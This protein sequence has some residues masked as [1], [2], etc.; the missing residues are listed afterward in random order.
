MQPDRTGL[1]APAMILLA[2]VLS[3]TVDAATFTVTSTGDSGAGSLRQALASANG[4]AGTDTIEFADGVVGTITL[5]TALPQIVE[6]VTIDGPGADVL[7]VNGEDGVQGVSGDD[8]VRPFSIATGVQV[9]ISGLTIA[10]GLALDEGSPGSGGGISNRGDLTLRDCTL[11]GNSAPDNLGGAV[12][13]A[14]GATLLVER[15]TISGNLADIGGGISNDGTLTV[16]DSRIE[17]NTAVSQGGGIDNA[18]QATISRSLVVGNDSLFGGGIGTGIPQGQSAGGDLF[19]VNSTMSGNSVSGEFAIGGGIDN[20][21]GS[22]E[23]LHATIARNQAPQGAGV[24]SDGD[25]AAKNSLVVENDGG[26]CEFIQ[27]SFAVSGANLATD[28]SCPNFT[29]VS[30][31][32]LALEN[33][34]DNGGATAT[35]AM[36]DSSVAVN[37]ALDCTGLDGVTP[38]A[39]DQRG[40]ERPQGAACEPGAFE[41][42]ADTI[43]A[44]GF[45]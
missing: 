3:T 13:N 4:S 41:S 16:I 43:F 39:T 36:A 8:G 24:S 5:V 38:V 37:A 30:P 42:D 7:S 40:V 10:D 20:F 26:D 2:G 12:D 15:C 6:A 45:E 28:D 1:L 22:V 11:T 17:G 9:T 35:H 34:A 33:L 21:N 32:A 27:G 29:A 23:L 19:V 18:G 44:D 25:F 14:P 31:G